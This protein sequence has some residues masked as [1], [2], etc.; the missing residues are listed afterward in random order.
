[1]KKVM[2]KIT[3]SASVVISLLITSIGFSFGNELD[4]IKAAIKSKGAK[5]TAEETSISR[6][7]PVERKL[8]VGNIKALTAG[9][10]QPDSSLYLLSAPTG[11]FDWRDNG[12]TNYVTPVRDQGACGSC[13]AFATTAALESNTLIY[14]S[15]S[16]GLNQ[17][18]QILVSC[19]G[20]GSCSG[21]YIDQASNF[22]RDTGLPP[23][24]YDP[25]TATNGSCSGAASGWQNVTD[26]IPSWHW[27]TTTSPTAT[28]VKDGLFTYGPLVTTM[29]V[30]SDFFSY[31]SGVYS[32]VSGTHQGGHAIL[33]VGYADD[34]AFPGGGYF[35]VKN[36]WG[37]GWG[38]SGFFRIAYG[39]LNSVVNFGDYTIAYD[40]SAPPPP[41]PP[42]CSYSIS[43][44]GKTIAATGGSGSFT[45]SVGSTCQW[46]AVSNVSW[47]SVASGT[48]GTGNGIVNYSVATA[49]AARTGTISVKDASSRV[50][51][52]TFTVTQQKPRRK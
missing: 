24:A 12:G 43:P 29:K 2:W 40:G 1:M 14:E 5:W 30:Y 27:V 20:A 11:N 50:V 45:V 38:E 31:R 37:T 36:S 34:A 39:E 25:Y 23:E 3:V 35:I 16:Q 47:I 44:T 4:E 13:W 18:E 8:R 17:A 15:Y 22:I 51:V 21:G 52:A 26:R 48:G 7:P 28:A 49:A 41:P 10:A 6:L 42:A 46:T 19:S 9:Q 33:I 32:Y